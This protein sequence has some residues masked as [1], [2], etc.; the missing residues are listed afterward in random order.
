MAYVDQQK[1]AKIA[2]ALK[3]VMPKGWKF[4]LAVNNHSTIVLTISAAP[5]NLI[6]ALVPSEY[7]K[8]ETM[9]YAQIYHKRIDECFNDA[10]ITATFEKISEA[11]NLENFD[12]SDSMTDYFHVGHY[13]DI[14][15][16]KWNKPFA[17]IAK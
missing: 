4:S 9:T 14:N 7:R 13:V 8:P 17:V 15:V 11:L 10:E 5:V 1:K 16:G 3:A 2:T 6:A 12:K